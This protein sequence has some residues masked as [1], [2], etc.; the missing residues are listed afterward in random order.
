M[1]EQFDVIVIGGGPG[2]MMA[3]LFASKHKQKVL[4]LEKNPVLGVKLS[5]TGGG[6]CNILNAEP[7]VRKLLKHYG[8]AADYLFSPFS[9]FGLEEAIT[10]F[11]ENGLPLKTEARN[12]MFPQSEKAPDV[13]KLLVTLLAK[14][15]VTVWTK[16]A[17]K[18]IEYDKA[19]VTGVTLLDGR[20]VTGKAII[21]ATGGMSHPETGSTGEGL[22][23]LETLGHTVSQPTPS[24]VP[25][26][27]SDA[28]VKKL[29]GLTLDPI[30]LSFKQN[31]EK[32]LEVRGRILLTHFGLTGPTVMNASQLI[33]EYLDYGPVTLEID[34]QPESD[35]GQLN[36][37]LLELLEA[38]RTKS[39]KNTLKLIVPGR[40]VQ[41]LL[42]KIAVEDKPSHALTREERNALVKILKHLTVSVTGLLG[43]DKAIVTSGGLALDEVDF[44]TM[45]SKKYPNLFVVGDVLDINRPSGG[46]SLQL[47]WTTGYV[48]GVSSAKLDK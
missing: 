21:L 39:L 27:V 30:K 47:C 36:Q 43:A 48:A 20:T 45:A 44:K 40:I 18:T 37:K 35:Y 23:W 6:R 24:L 12:R 5:Q 16:A 31:E 13:T 2:G 29:P 11:E 4:L 3:A 1:T 42:E 38:N 33:S 46:F 22:S 19:Q 9:Q 8:N 41:V 15:Q 34:L 17:V 7:D 14:N 32:L 28:W 25:M 26:K 10:F